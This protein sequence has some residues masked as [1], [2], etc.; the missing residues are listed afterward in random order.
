MAY[1]P[2]WFIFVTI[3]EPFASFPVLGFSQQIFKPYADK[4][5]K[6]MNS[7]IHEPGLKW[8]PAE[9]R[10]AMAGTRLYLQSDG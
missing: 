2:I 3:L 10:V 7:Q 1:M 5:N 4:L 8:I 9:Q 6:R